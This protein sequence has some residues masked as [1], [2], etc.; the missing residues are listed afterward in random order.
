M[1]ENNDRTVAESQILVGKVAG[2]MVILVET[3]SV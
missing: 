1:Q 2:D 3:S